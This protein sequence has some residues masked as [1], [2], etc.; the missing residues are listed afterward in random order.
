MAAT[1]PSR[2]GSLRTAR[3]F[4]PMPIIMWAEILN[5]GELL[6]SVSEGAILKRFMS[7]KVRLISPEFVSVESLWLGGEKA[8]LLLVPDGHA[9]KLV[10]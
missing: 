8:M 7:K 3:G 4:T 5:F 10:E 9:L 6:C 1:K 2:C